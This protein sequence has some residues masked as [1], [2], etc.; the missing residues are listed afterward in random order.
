MNFF[1]FT[2]F[3]KIIND[4]KTRENSPKDQPFFRKKNKKYTCSGTRQ[5]Q[6]R[7]QVFFYSLNKCV[8]SEFGTHFWARAS[9]MTVKHEGNSVFAWRDFYAIKH[10][11]NSPTAK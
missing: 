1:N 10:E 11:E 9:G 8:L 6:S 3:R 7:K 2:K 5:K 4:C